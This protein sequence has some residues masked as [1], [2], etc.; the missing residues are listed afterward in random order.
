[1]PAPLLS[2]PP[3]LPPPAPPPAPPLQQQ[4]QQQQQQQEEEEYEEEKEEEDEEAEHS[5]PKYSVNSVVSTSR[6]DSPDTHEDRV[7]TNTE[8]SNDEFPVHL[9]NG[10]D[11]EGRPEEENIAKGKEGKKTCRF[12]KY[13]AKRRAYGV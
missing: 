13:P 6:S 10:S 3:P 7:S 9:G 2:L 12:Y 5:T 4:Q 1:M 11:V 8:K